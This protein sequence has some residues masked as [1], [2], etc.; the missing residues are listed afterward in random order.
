MISLEEWEKIRNR[1]LEEIDHEYV[2]GNLKLL[3]ERGFYGW[4]NFKDL[5]D[6]AMRTMYY[7]KPH[8]FL[9]D[10]WRVEE[11]QRL[12]KFDRDLMAAAL[13][14]GG[15]ISEVLMAHADNFTLDEG[16]LKVS[17][18]P[19]LKRVDRQTFK[20]R[21]IP[22]LEAIQIGEIPEGYVFDTETQCFIE[23][24]VIVKSVTRERPDFPIPLWEPFIDLLQRRI[25]N[26]EPGKGGYRWLFPTTATPTR[27]E[28]P[29]IQKWIEER[30]N[31]ETRAWISPERAWQKV[32]SI[33]ERQ[34]Y[35]IWDHW[36]RSQRATQLGSE[37][38]FTKRQLN[39]FFGWESGGSRGEETAD[40]YTTTDYRGL[41]MQMAYYRSFH[42]TQAKEV[43]Q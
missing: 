35:K 31:M 2:R 27:K 40:L 8:P 20:G 3:R 19:V 37:Y 13:L 41:K 7:E 34:G 11:R 24:E 36:F 38:Q 29:G 33:G 6:E 23:Q 30:F 5:L 39:H 9:K 16:F 10:D 28:D 26:A 4:S 25:G 15:R 43:K 12:R 1:K 42:E 22:L 18:L 14:I 21:K 17:K 32:T